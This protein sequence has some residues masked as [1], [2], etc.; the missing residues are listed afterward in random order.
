MALMQSIL[1]ALL[2]V[3]L[4]KVCMP[5]KMELNGVPPV[6]MDW[7]L[8]VTMTVFFLCSC[9]STQMGRMPETLMD[10]AGVV[11]FT[12][13]GIKLGIGILVPQMVQVLNIAFRQL[14]QIR[15]Y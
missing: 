10:L 4:G 1:L 11:T 5:A 9:G 7:H 8:A 12:V 6:K 2:Q 15:I 14:F 13:G 3:D